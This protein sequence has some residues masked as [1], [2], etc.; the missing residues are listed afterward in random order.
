MKM[1][2]VLLAIGVLLPVTAAAAR[3][4]KKL[5]PPTAV[6]DYVRQTT[7]WAERHG[8]SGQS[9]GSLYSPQARFSDLVRDL[10]ASQV[11]DL[12][13][14]VVSDSASAV[15]TGAT[16][17]ARKSAA[18][19][20]VTQLAGKTK[21]T[22][23]WANLLGLDGQSKL[24]GQGTTSR[25]TTLTTTLSARVVDVLPNGYLVLQ[26]DKDIAIN[27]ESQRVQVRGVV[28]WNDI[29]PSNQVRSDRLAAVEIRI[30]GKGV[31]G[32]AIRRPNFLYRLL[33]GILPF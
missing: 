3:K 10:R 1:V 7:D 24:D 5:P 30:N 33:L 25:Q 9:P 27:S 18:S 19:A 11:G 26:G 28:R 22:G 12:V 6:E 2:R 16:S 29:T 32:D 8:Q 14:V 4:T 31:V 20:S 15:S 21:A 13:T 23:P 17:T